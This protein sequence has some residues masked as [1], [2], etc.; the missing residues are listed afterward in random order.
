MSLVSLPPGAEPLRNVIAR[1][2]FLDDTELE[3][4]VS[5]VKLTVHKSCNKIAHA[6]L[7]II[8]GSP[9]DRDFPHSN[10]DRFKPGT[11]IEV[12][13]GIGTDSDTVFKGI[14]IR[15]GIRAR[16]D[17]P[18]LLIIEAKDEA[19]KLTN[20]RKSRY[21]TNKTDSTIITELAT[22]PEKDIAPTTVM[23]P[24]MVQYDATDWDFILTRAE[25]N[26]MLVHTDD[27][28]LIVKKPAISPS[29]FTATYGDNIREIEA[30][31]DA[32]RQ[33]K[34]VG[35]L[36]WDY[37]QQQ[38]DEVANGTAILTETGNLPSDELADV[39][40]AEVKLNHV[41]AISHNELQSWADAYVLRSKLSKAVGRV[42]V[43][44]T[45]DVKPGVMITLNGVGDRFNGDVFVSGV[46]HQYD[47]DWITDIQFGWK[48][49]WFYKKE[50]VMDRPAGGLLPGITG[51][52]IGVVQKGNDSTEVLKQ[53]RVKVHVPTITTGEDGI[54]ARV[55]TPDA[56]ENRGYYFRPQEGDEVILGFLND[57]PREAIILGYLHSKGKNNAPFSDTTDSM[58]EFGIMTKE[59][60]KIVFDDTNKKLTI[61][62]PVGTQEKTIVLNDSGAIE[63]KDENN[64]SIKMDAS[65]IT[66]QSSANVVIKGT[67]V[68]IN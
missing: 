59:K 45:S 19:I 15:H 49:E 60:L 53:Y 10:E 67:M 8:D 9:A 37:T 34:T 44:G 61:S 56:G 7:T 64:N 26:G 65:G 42:R 31:M 33:F 18:P 58:Q 32:R 50:D 55:A 13:L 63:I 62:A 43:N 68:Q 23:H 51:L 40:E 21:F 17:G 57:D 46:L 16:A 3:G 48:E 11:P 22:T 14:I 38:N 41:G 24:Q 2:V 20:A 54:W 12:R 35:A 28:K 29:V 39:L 27:N 66:I 5:L 47:G 25:A 52:Q 30:D 36:S 6:T 1:K 4:E